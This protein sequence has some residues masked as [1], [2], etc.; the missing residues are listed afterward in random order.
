MK[1]LSFGSPANTQ[2]KF[3]LKSPFLNGAVRFSIKL[4]DSVFLITGE[5]EQDGFVSLFVLGLT[6]GT[7]AV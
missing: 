1:T 5:A 7:A 2:A 6:K 4:R 3:N